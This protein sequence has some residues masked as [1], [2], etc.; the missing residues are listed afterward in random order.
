MPKKRVIKVKTP[1]IQFL[2]IETD[3]KSISTQTF[4]PKIQSIKIPRAISTTPIRSEKEVNKLVIEFTSDQIHSPKNYQHFRPFPV[5]C[6]RFVYGST[7]HNSVPRSELNGR[8]GSVRSRFNMYDTR[9]RSNSNP[10]TPKNIQISRLKKHLPSKFVPFYLRSTNDMKRP[11]SSQERVS[12]Q[13]SSHP[14]TPTKNSTYITNI[15][16]TPTRLKSSFAKIPIT[17]I[18][19]K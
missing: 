16:I 5:K 3:D 17:Y 14:L 18:N 10:A 4:E 2:S 15:N 9:N 1:H 13:R 8:R 19:P 7:R 11:S 6:K 12:R